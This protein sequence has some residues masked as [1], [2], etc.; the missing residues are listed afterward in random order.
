MQFYCPVC[1]KTVDATEER[2]I[3]TKLNQSVHFAHC[4]TC[5]QEMVVYGGN[6][7]P[8]STQPSASPVLTPQP[9]AP[10]T[11]ATP[12]ADPAALPNVEQAQVDQALKDFGSVV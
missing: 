11:L 12:V 4:P 3:T 1:Q 8:V 9:V 6:T 10:E 2:S 7:I 5:Q